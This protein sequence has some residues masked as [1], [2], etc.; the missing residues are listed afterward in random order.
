MRIGMDSW[1]LKYE[2]LISAST[3]EPITLDMMWEMEWMEPL[4]RERVVGALDMSG[5]MSPR[6]YFP[7]ARLRDRGSE[8]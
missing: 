6:K 3:A 8:R 1:P 2:A 4:R 7:A 5:R